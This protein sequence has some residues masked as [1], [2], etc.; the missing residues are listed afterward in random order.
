MAPKMVSLR[1]R[2]CM[3]VSCQHAFLCAHCQHDA[4]AQ[5]SAAQLCPPGYRSSKR[6]FRRNDSR[7]ACTLVDMLD[8]IFILRCNLRDCRGLVCIKVTF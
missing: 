6:C 2:I 1:I 4:L 7:A 5:R 3:C 8:M